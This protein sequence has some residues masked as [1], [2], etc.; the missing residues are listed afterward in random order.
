MIILA[1]EEISIIINDFLK[2]SDHLAEAADN[3]KVNMIKKI[4][5]VELINLNN[6]FF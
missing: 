2:G 3:N 4:K 6:L 1:T 5:I